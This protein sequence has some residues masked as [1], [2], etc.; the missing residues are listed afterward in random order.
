MKTELP[1]IAERLDIVELIFNL[2]IKQ[3]SE[4]FSIVLDQFK[5]ENV[6][7]VLTQLSEPIEQL[8]DSL[9]LEYEKAVDY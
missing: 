6:Q 9:E 3:E 5:V 4:E 8:F 2:V 7:W 1:D